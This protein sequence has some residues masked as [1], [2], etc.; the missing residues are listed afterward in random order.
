MFRVIVVSCG[1]IHNSGF[2]SCLSDE[3]YRLGYEWWLPA[4]TIRILILTSM[5]G[6]I[7]RSCWIKMLVAQIISVAFLAL[8]LWVRPCTSPI[9]VCSTQ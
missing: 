8:F 4:E 2:V 5:V 7:S 6:F 9:I 1:L 3:P